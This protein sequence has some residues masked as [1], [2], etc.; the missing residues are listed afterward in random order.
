MNNTT[1]TARSILS[2]AIPPTGCN[3]TPIWGVALTY[4]IRLDQ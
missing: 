4:R 3:F 1:R 2:W